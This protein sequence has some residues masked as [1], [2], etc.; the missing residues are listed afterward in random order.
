MLARIRPDTL[1]WLLVAVN[2]ALTAF[3][4]WC[5]LYAFNFNKT[6]GV[7]LK[8][9]SWYKPIEG[10]AHLSADEI[11]GYKIPERSAPPPVAGKPQ[12]VALAF[13]PMVPRLPEEKVNEE[14]ADLA[15][16]S[17]VEGGPLSDKWTLESVVWAEGPAQTY[18][19]LSEKQPDPARP[20]AVV[21]PGTTFP[22]AKT[23]ASTYR[24]PA[25]GAKLQSK[26]KMLRVY[27]AEVNAHPVEIGE[28]AIFFVEAQENP[29]AIVYTEAGLENSEDRY[30]FDPK[31]KKYVLK[32]E[33]EVYDP[34][35]LKG[36][37]PNEDPNAPAK[38]AVPPVDPDSRGSISVGGKTLQATT[39]APAAAPPPAA[40]GSRIVSSS[41]ASR[42]APPSAKDVQELKSA[43]NDMKKNIPPEELKKI[44]EA[45]TG[46]KK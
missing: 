36:R 10:Y 39:P 12:A 35:V 21:R 15:E 30:V 2:V 32:K 34:L 18:A 46:G 5:A 7:A 6:V 8:D 28:R 26:Q 31:A 44:N 23:T 13:E 19:F 11:K 38:K 29:V 40:S 43:I 16:E 24:R 33:E 14:P 25:A 27:D 20:A 3:L 45:M 9:K 22:A 1:R 17:A 41:P 37:D 42:P 4:G